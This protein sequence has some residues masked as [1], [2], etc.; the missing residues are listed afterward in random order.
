M[1]SR[2][3]EVRFHHR[4]FR[5]RAR[6]RQAAEILSLGHWALGTPSDRRPRGVVPCTR[7]PVSLLVATMKQWLLIATA[8]VVLNAA[9]WALWGRYLARPVQP[10]H[11]SRRVVVELAAREPAPRVPVPRLVP[12]RV[13]PHV[14][15][16]CVAQP[17]P[18]VPR[19]IRARR[20]PRPTRI[21]RPA[22]PAR[23]AP[24]PRPSAARPRPRAAARPALQ[25]T[26]VRSVSAS[27]TR[28]TPSPPQR[29]PESTE[30]PAAAAAHG[31]TSRL[32]V[33][34]LA[35]RSDARSRA[36]A[37]LSSEGLA[38]IRQRIRRALQ[39]Q[40]H[41]PRLARQRGVEGVVLLAFRVG[42]DGQVRDLRVVRSAGG[43]LDQAA[44]ETVLRAAPLPFCPRTIRVPLRYALED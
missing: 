40:R 16:R 42:R 18:A 44:R 35:S 17:H 27:S 1:S 10:A 12:E 32:S 11:A 7:R 9:G 2:P 41:Y 30:H 37:A 14:P 23:P 19:R 34:V 6:N 39:R 15:S 21:A 36:G 29:R 43:V 25:V 3:P 33:G 13:A 26:P 20:R 28:A 22:R 5:R 38:A 4:W 31:G 8:S 24:A